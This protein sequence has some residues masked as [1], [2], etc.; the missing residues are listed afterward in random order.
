M[1]FIS[2]AL[3]SC[4]PKEPIDPPNPPVT[5]EPSFDDEL[6]I[7]WQLSLFAD[8]SEA[9]S[10]VPEVYNNNV[11]FS[12]RSYTENKE[13]FRL[14]NG[15]TGEIIWTR[16]DPECFNIPLKA[17]AKSNNKLALCDN[18]NLHV[19]DLDTGEEMW[20]SV[21]F[22][23]RLRLAEIN[24]NV[25]WTYID[26]GFKPDTCMLIRSEFGMQEWKNVLTLTKTN[27]FH[28]GIEPPVSWENDNGET[29]LIFQNRSYNFEIGK[30]KIDLYAFNLDQEVIEWVKEDIT[31][32]GNSSI[33]QPIV[34]DNKVYFQ[35]SSSLHCFDIAT[36]EL[37]WERLF[38]GAGFLTCNMV[39][40]D[41]RLIANGDAQNI[42]AL[43]SST[44][45]TI[46]HNTTLKSHNAGNMIAYDGV[47]YFTSEGN[48]TLCAVKVSDGSILWEETTPNYDGWNSA[49]FLSGIAI[50]EDLGYL[51]AIDGF[52][53][54][55]IK[56]PK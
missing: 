8:S 6:N 37:V 2:I 11:V 41:G 52:Y 14:Y 43:N 56:L 3:A 22:S 55:C 16:D 45:E 24:D 50:N 5:E 12:S 49:A 53:A 18:A 28:P 48:G 25:F 35:G 31:E 23:N 15:S 26:K 40:T 38:A 29:I 13:V 27:D 39:M 44:G 1:L 32:S 9:N 17:Q 21:E 51:Y 7:I 30:G 20:H 4:K 46:W 42:W 36:G 54:M 34:F 10:I 19:L 33:Y 47:V